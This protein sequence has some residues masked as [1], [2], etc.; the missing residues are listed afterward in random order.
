M[1]VTF[2]VD[3][4]FVAHE[5]TIMLN[6]GVVAMAAGQTMAWAC[7]LYVFPALLLRWEQSLG[8]SKTMLTVAVSLALVMSAVF[9]PL[10][11]RMIDHGKGAMLMAASCCVGGVA[12]FLLS[13]IAEPWQFLALSALA[14]LSLIHI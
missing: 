13:M 11:G 5:K 3:V 12:I 8:W 6:R 7:L 4:I 10:A 14:G 2:P 9:S 1:I